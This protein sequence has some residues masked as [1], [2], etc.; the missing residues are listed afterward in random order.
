MTLLIILLAVFAGIALMVILGEKF[1]K[2]MN[3][4]EQAKYSKII[5]I[6]V[7]VLLIGSLIKMLL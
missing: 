1:G 6:L 5:P 2:P 3:N 7:F 4:E